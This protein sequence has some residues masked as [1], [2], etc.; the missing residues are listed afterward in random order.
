MNKSPEKEQYGAENVLCRWRNNRLVRGVLAGL[1]VWAFLRYILPLT[2]PFVLAFLVISLFYPFLQR[3]QRKVPVKKKFLAVAVAVP[4][5]ILLFWVL[6]GLCA[7][8]CDQLEKLPRLWGDMEGQ[9][10]QFFHQCC[11]R[12]DG[13]MGWNGQEMEEM[14]TDRMDGVMDS[15]QLQIM[16]G[17]V[18]SS[19]YCFRNLIAS[20]GFLAVTLIAMILLE[21]DYA[22][23]L[24]KLKSSEDTAIVWRVTEGVISYLVT[25]LKAQGI[26]LA[27]ISLMC[28]V[29]LKLAGVEGAVGIGLLAGFLDMMPFI[30]TG[31]VLVPLSVWQLVNLHYGKMVVCLILY[32]ACAL[33]REWLEPKLIGR[34]VGIAP[35]CLLLGIYAGVRLFGAAGIIKGPL[36]LVILYEILKNQED[37]HLPEQKSGSGREIDEPEKGGYDGRS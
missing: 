24:D 4:F 13:L 17:I 8:G 27:A 33:L 3:L 2:A 23:F 16:P 29:V 25:F 37:S 5:L 6:W 12:I 14:L 11:C 7:A 34:R 1:F 26:I 31:I 20:A 36:G 32:G 35:V 28:I 9:M 30:G 18:S 15:L 10:E 22:A 21:K 19:Y